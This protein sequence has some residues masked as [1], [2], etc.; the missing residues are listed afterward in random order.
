[1]E[2]NNERT[3]KS[4]IHVDQQFAPHLECAMLGKCIINT[5]YVIVILDTIMRTSFFFLSDTSIQQ[6]F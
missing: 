1:M 6:T 2:Q 3:E 4:R 5:Q